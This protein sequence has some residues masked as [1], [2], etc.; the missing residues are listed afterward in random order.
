M[1]TEQY[2]LLGQRLVF[3]MD[4]KITFLTAQMSPLS[5]AEVEFGEKK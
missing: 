2:C 4:R 1:G 3:P 5:G